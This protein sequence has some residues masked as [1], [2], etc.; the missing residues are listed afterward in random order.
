MYEAFY[1]LSAGPFQLNPD[2][3]F[4]F[5]SAGHRRAY[6]YLQY[7]V[8]QGEGFVVVTGE[9][10]AGKTTL[11]RALLTE[12]DAQKVI[13]A[14]LVSTQLDADDLL[15][16][17]AIAFGLPGKANRKAELVNQIQKFLVDLVPSGRRA[18][19]VVDE[20]QNLTPD[21][22]EE[23]RALSSFQ[24]DGRHLLQ[25]FLVGQPE[26]RKLMRAPSMRQLRERVIASY[27]LGPMDE[28][29][30][31]A[32]IEHRLAHVGWKNDPEFDG[33]AFALIFKMTGGIPRRI[34]SLCNRLLLGAYLSERHHLHS[35]DVAKA[36]GE[37]C[38]E[39]G[40]DALPPEAP[41][42]PAETPE[43]PPETPA[44]EPAPGSAVEAR[45]ADFMRSQMLSSLT[46][47]LDRLERNVAAILEIVQKISGVEAT[48]PVVKRAGT[49]RVPSPGSGPPNMPTPATGRR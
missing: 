3:E 46:A 18:L 1:G 26:L 13:A 25:S 29:E 11:V 21:A 24:L 30:T 37:M 15:R 10:G 22:V 32:Y 48:K 6:A 31:R 4:Y 19:L 2:A 47:R 35:T 43:T 17:V 23:L 38:E 5:E 28:A 7:G 41:E 45:G 33:A 44:A 34:N 20:A 16:S 8:A 49:A 12:L 40:A 14:Q 36:A 9:V 27:H 39:M 42:A